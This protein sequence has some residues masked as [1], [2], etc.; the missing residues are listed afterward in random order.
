L[1]GEE[2]LGLEA[3]EILRRATG[4]DAAGRYEMLADWVLPSPDHPLVRLEGEFTPSDGTHGGVLRA[5]AIELVA[6]AKELGKLDELVR[7]LAASPGAG[8]VD[9]RGRLAFAMLIALARDD[10]GAASEALARIKPLVAKLPREAQE[11]QRWP[12]LVAA[13]AAVAR[14]ETRA[15]ALALVEAMAG[16]LPGED[17]RGPLDA[18][19][20]LW[21]HQVKHLL[22]EARGLIGVRPAA[23]PLGDGREEALWVR[24]VH[25]GSEGGLG[26][27]PPGAWKVRAGAFEHVPGGFTD[28][29]YLRVPIRGEFQVDCELSAGAGRTIRLGYGGTIVGLS[30]DGKH[31]ERSGFGRGLPELAVNP[32][33]E[34]KG[35]WAQWRLI[36]RPGQITALVDGRQVYQ[37]PLA[38]ECDP[39]LVL[40]C[41]PGEAGSVRNLKISG[42]PAVVDDLVLSSRPDLDG[43]MGSGLAVASERV[44]AAWDKRGAEIVGPHDESMRGSQTER[45]LTYHHPLV[46][47]GTLSYEFYHEPGKALVHPALGRLVFLLDAEG[48]RLHRLSDGTD[49]RSDEPEG[50]RADSLPLRAK[51]W[52][53]LTVSLAGDRVELRLNGVSIAQRVLEPS[54]DRTFGLF[55][56][57]DETEAR[58]RNVHYRGRWP[59]ELP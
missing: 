57:A 2:V 42:A 7:R 23:R 36:V 55:H 20:P 52:N 11:W 6:A 17:E 51:A 5:P 30:R 8:D 56:F 46:E 25:D 12:E 28:L 44:E 4:R 15:E 40:S 29:L 45:L 13:T 3:G 19:S 31:V 48:V 59:R 41:A 9:A 10:P 26:G 33:V 32:P 35:E 22:A 27:E 43:W 14:D 34:P 38:V 50:H 54:N 18:I 39:W 37:T 24:V 58:V 49:E 16:Q 21:E 47:D 53:E 1:I